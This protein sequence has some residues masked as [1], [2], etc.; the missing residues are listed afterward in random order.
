MWDAL[1]RVHP[2]GDV[3]S[4][5]ILLAIMFLL[6]RRWWAGYWMLNQGFAALTSI[7]AVVVGLLRSDMTLV[8]Y[9]GF[10][11]LTG[12]CYGVWFKNRKR[13]HADK[14][15]RNNF[16]PGKTYRYADSTG[17]VFDG[18]IITVNHDVGMAVARDDTGRDIVIDTNALRKMLETGEREK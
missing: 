17:L 10:W 16:A 18:T 14:L 1:L 15:I 2:W 7:P 3:Q 9:H 8:Y 13:W 4:L 6:P 11:V 5:A 12:V